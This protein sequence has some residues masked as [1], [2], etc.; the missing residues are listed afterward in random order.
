[1]KKYAGMFSLKEIYRIGRGPSSSH[2]MG[3]ERAAHIFKDKHFVDL[4]VMVKLPQSHKVTRQTGITTNAISMWC[5][6]CR[7]KVFVFERYSIAHSWLI[8]HL[9]T[10]GH[11][12]GKAGIDDSSLNTTILNDVHYFCHKRTCLPS[13]STSWFENHFQ[14][15]ISSMKALQSLYQ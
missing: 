4:K 12:T 6:S 10:I 11:M 1:M 7:F 9:Q 14:M 13:K 15:R 8:R 2:T 5:V 3:P